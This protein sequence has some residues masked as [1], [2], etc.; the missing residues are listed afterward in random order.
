M[1]ASDQ[2]S[3]WWEVDGSASAANVSAWVGS[4]GSSVSPEVV[5][6]HRRRACA[7]YKPD[8]LWGMRV[9]D[10][11][12]DVDTKSAP[13]TPGLRMEGKAQ[14]IVSRPS[15]DAN[16]DW[17][18]QLRSWGL[19]P[20]EWVVVGAPRLSIWEAQQKGGGVVQM[21]AWKAQV[22]RIEDEN[23]PTNAVLRQAEPINVKVNLGKRPKQRKP[24]G[25]EL[26]VLMPDA[27]RPF[28][29]P[30][31]VDVSLQVLAHAERTHGVDKII[32][33]GDDLDLPD[34][35]SHRTAPDVLGQLNAAF[36]SQY[37]VLSTERE[38]CPNSEIVWLEGNHECRATNWMVDNAPHLLGLHRP[39]EEP[40][41]PVLSVPYLCRLDELGV[42]YIAPYPEGEVWLNDHIRCIHGTT[43]KAQ[44]GSTAAHYLTQGNF[45]TVYG[46]IHRAELLYQTRHT[47]LGPRTYMAGSPGSL[48]HLD[49]SVPSTKSGINSSGKQGKSITENWQNGIWLLFYQVDGP[50]LFSV[51][52]VQIWGGW[53][54]WR[55]MDFHAEVC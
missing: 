3:L 5:Q 7:C 36:S 40:E 14:T 4:R 42:E 47:R 30:A 16:I 55:G 29:D 48:C 34:F 19:N 50:Q 45:S 17:E 2:E 28:E 33:L 35:G 8:G 1:S 25:W 54:Q 31:A 15:T 11:V 39:G 18:D 37:K 10:P 9:S 21:H 38:T 13:V 41:D 22:E 20:D 23:G 44:L 24:E 43:A 49:G 32:H 6:R 51:E 12:E 53:A 27:Q 26:A 46:H 52:P